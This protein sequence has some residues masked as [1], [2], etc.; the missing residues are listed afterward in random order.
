[1]QDIHPYFLA[2][3]GA[4]D[5]KQRDHRERHVLGHVHD[6]VPR[7]PPRPR[8]VGRLTNDASAA[9]CSGKEMYGSSPPTC[10]SS[11]KPVIDRANAGTNT[12]AIANPTVDVPPGSPQGTPFFTT[13]ESGVHPDA[14]ADARDH[15]RGDG[16]A[17][18]E[19]ELGRVLRRAGRPVDRLGHRHL[20]LALGVGANAEGPFQLLSTPAPSPAAAPGSGSGQTFALNTSPTKPHGIGTCVSNVVPGYAGPV[21]ANTQ[22]PT[23]DHRDPR[24]VGV[25]PFVTRIR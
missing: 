1:M 13:L 10:G 16:V 17:G 12:Q 20:R 5:F 4:E 7:N 6:R 15:H 9:T 3:G 14:T 18:R 24:L 8:P 23:F 11:T 19:R 22:Y 25:I 21:P 2:E